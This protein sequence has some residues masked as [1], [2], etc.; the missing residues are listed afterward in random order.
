MATETLPDETRPLLPTRTAVG[1]TGQA[2]TG[3]GHFMEWQHVNWWKRPSVYML[4]FVVALF[5]S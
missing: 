1:V 4:Y 2:V 3:D 5:T